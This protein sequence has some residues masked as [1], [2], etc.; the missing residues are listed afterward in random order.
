LKTFPGKVRCTADPSAALGA[1]DFFDLF[2]FSADQLVVF[3]PAGKAVI[4]SGAE[5]T[6]AAFN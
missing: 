2:V 4:L 1:C 6:S 5:G 3:K